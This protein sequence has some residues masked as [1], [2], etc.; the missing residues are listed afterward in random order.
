MDFIDRIL[1]VKQAIKKSPEYI[2]E[3]IKDIDFVG[4]F[5]DFIN[6]KK[7]QKIFVYIGVCF[8]LFFVLYLLNMHL[9]KLDG[10]SVKNLKINNSAYGKITY[11]GDIKNRKIVGDGLLTIIG[12]KWA[13]EFSGTFDE[14]PSFTNTRDVQI[15]DF[16]KGT[17]TI[18][19]LDSGNKYILSGEFD[20]MDLKEGTIEKIFS[21]AT[22][23]YT[24]NFTK[25]KL[26][27]LG[28][29]YVYINGKSKTFKGVFIDNKL[30]SGD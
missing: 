17:I 22:I 19:N 2:S 23:K 18:V 28:E 12:N 14:S 10:P 7:V 8:A 25:Y 6:S 30:K 24:G 4:S 11:S 15:G 3:D 13:V 1:R 27:G 21:D 29:K 5:N 16:S 20:D 9:T 26:N